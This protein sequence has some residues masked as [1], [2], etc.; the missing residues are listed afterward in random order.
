MNIKERYRMSCQEIDRH[1]VMK[2]VE[3]QELNL[4]EASEQLH[5]SYRQTKRLWGAYKNLGILGIL[6]KNKGKNRSFPQ[7]FKDQVMAAVQG[8]YSDFGPTLA[9]EKLK[10]IDGLKINRET[11]RQWMIGANLWAGK[12]RRKA[13]IHQTRERRARLGELVQVDGSPHAWLEDRGP[14]CCALVFIDDATS[15]LMALRFEPSETT[16]GYFRAT[17]TYIETHGRPLC[18]YSDKDSV[19]LVARK[20]RIDG[21]RGETQYQRAMRQLGI[22]MILANSPQAKGRVERANQTL[23]DRLIKEMRLRGINT[24]EAANH[25]APE[26]I[27]IY[28]E[29]FE[30]PAKNPEDAHLPNSHTS[31]DLHRILSI[32]TS[33]KLSKNLEFSYLKKLYQIQRLGSG[34]ALRYTSVTVC[35]QMDGNIEILR[36]EESLSYKVCEP[37]HPQPMI[38]DTK[39]LNHLVDVLIENNQKVAA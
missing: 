11:L 10:E 28:N 34:Y 21:L 36:N 33:R 30:K 20:D 26:F 17:K 23:Q 7:D 6:S 18:F 16:M 5:L 37:H 32:Q 19:F 25:F 38:C 15:K 31:A 22:K 1:E 12:K 8:K 14:Y 35:E 27:K 9:S 13:R 24:I 39:E 4:I 29:K 2:R 3:R